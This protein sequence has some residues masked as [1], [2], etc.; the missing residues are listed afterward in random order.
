MHSSKK[1]QSL[2][3]NFFQSCFHFSYL[4]NIIINWLITFFLDL[5]RSLPG[6][7]PN[8]CCAGAPLPTA[9]WKEASLLSRKVDHLYLY[10]T[11]VVH[12][13]WADESYIRWVMVVKSALYYAFLG[14]FCPS[15]VKLCK[16]IIFFFKTG[17]F[18]FVIV[19]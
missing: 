7:K 8:I 16:K 9:S 1:S 2:A 12:A 15:Y 6:K 19:H 5:L 11:Q 18:Y 13:A 10:L 4:V 3:F 17:Q 14:T